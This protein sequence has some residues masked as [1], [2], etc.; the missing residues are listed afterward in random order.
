MR[1]VILGAVGGVATL[2]TLATAVQANGYN[3]YPVTT[4][5]STSA[6]ASSMGL[7]GAGIS[8]VIWC[9]VALVFLLVPIVLAIIVYKDAMK[10]NVE[11]AVLWALL[12][13]FFNIVGLLVY[14]L[15]IRPEALKKGAGMMKPMEKSEKMDEDKK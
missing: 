1:K 8:L 2:L 6:A 4:D 7:A 10:N 3:Y 9:C 11:N 13:F 5:L 15:A 12:T 14:Y